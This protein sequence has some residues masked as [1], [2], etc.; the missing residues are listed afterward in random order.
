MSPLNQKLKLQVLLT[1]LS[2][3]ENVGDDEQDERIGHVHGAKFRFQVAD[4][5]LSSNKHS[6]TIR[7]AFI[8]AMCLARETSLYFLASLDKYSAIKRTYLSS[9][10]AFERISS[11]TTPNF[12]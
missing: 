6:Q 3:V 7:T 12:F 9:S 2:Q 10:E 8:K 1:Y 5:R 4:D 11:S